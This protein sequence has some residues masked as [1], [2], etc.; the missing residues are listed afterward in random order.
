MET[1]YIFPLQHK[2][3]K[4]EINLNHFSEK[5]QSLTNH[6]TIV[7]NTIIVYIISFKN[8]SLGCT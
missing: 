3:K 1:A 6:L 7:L 4:N 5:L 2:F 8:V